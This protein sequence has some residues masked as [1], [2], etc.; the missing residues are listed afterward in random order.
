VVVGQAG[1][2]DA[3]GLVNPSVRQVLAAVEQRSRDRG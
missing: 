3:V 2:V 1:S